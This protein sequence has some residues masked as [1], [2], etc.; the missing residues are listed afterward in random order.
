MTPSVR[1][2][3]AE[4]RRLE[5]R[6]MRHLRYGA[7]RRCSRSR[8]TSAILSGLLRPFNAACA[9]VCYAPNLKPQC[10]HCSSVNETLPPQLEHFASAW[11]VNLTGA[12]SVFQASGRSTRPATHSNNS[13]IPA[14][15]PHSVSNQPTLQA[16]AVIAQDRRN[17]L[18]TVASIAATDFMTHNV[19]HERRDAAGQ[20]CR[21]TSTRWS[22]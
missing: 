8:R 10:G 6:V 2:A 9:K 1:S 7:L 18:S 5:Q 14:L 11:P 3:V 17:E 13:G 12:R 20:A 15:C 22:G 16:T 21:G 19:R 4:G